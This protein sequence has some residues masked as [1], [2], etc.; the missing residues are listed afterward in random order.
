MYFDVKI[1]HDY[2]DEAGKEKRKTS[3][4]IVKAVSFTDAEARAIECAQN[5]KLASFTVRSIAISKFESVVFNSGA[6]GSDSIDLFDTYLKIEDDDT[7]TKCHHLTYSPEI[8]QVKRIIEKE[9]SGWL[10]KPTIL[11]IKKM[12]V[13]FLDL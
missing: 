11:S 10:S 3:L 5:D 4:Y 8:D 7:T 1:K 13:A 12:D 2:V 6:A 9:S